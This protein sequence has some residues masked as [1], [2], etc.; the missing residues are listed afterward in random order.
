MFNKTKVNPA[1]LLSAIYALLVSVLVFFPNWFSRALANC[2][3]VILPAFIY[4]IYWLSHQER[5][6][7]PLKYFALYLCFFVYALL[8]HLI[9]GELM[10]V[11]LG[12]LLMFLV[13]FA[14]FTFTSEEEMEKGTLLLMKVILVTSLVFAILNC[15]TIVISNRFASPSAGNIITRSAWQII[16]GS[17][18]CYGEEGRFSG[19]AFQ[20]NAT[21]TN[22]LGGVV[23]AVYLFV[24]Q[25]T[26]VWKILSVL[27]IAFSL[28]IVFIANSRGSILFFI[29]FLVCVYVL[30]F[31]AFLRAVR[32]A[33]RRALY[34]LAFIFISA[35][36]LVC[37]FSIPVS[38]AF[39]FEEIM[40]IEYDSSLG[41]FDNLKTV[42]RQMQDGTGRVNLREGYYESLNGHLFFGSAFSRLNEYATQDVFHSAAHNSYVTVL[43]NTGL[44]GLTLYLACIAFSF[45]LNIRLF[46]DAWK[47]GDEYYLPLSAILFS[48]NIASAI[49]VFFENNLYVAASASALFQYYFLAAPIALYFLR[50][51]D[52]IR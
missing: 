5:T 10:Q 28:Y 31:V 49:Y 41:F 22:L 48:V 12:D 13:F 43:A 6:R 25:K 29:V 3:V 1:V 50:N 26:F 15:L 32:G 9:H 46:A 11:G 27:S 42:G 16:N 35:L 45:Y 37:L 38:R 47:K 7:I 18:A 52:N 8:L 44:I 20:P 40:R 39:I 51:Q 23:A 19:I 4:V 34:F 24:F 36:A 33:K 14:V 17:V 2:L 21:S 30:L